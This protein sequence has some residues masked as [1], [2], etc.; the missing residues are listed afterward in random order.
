MPDTY[1][2]AFYNLFSIDTVQFCSLTFQTNVQHTFWH[3]WEVVKPLGDQ[4]MDRQSKKMPMAAT[5]LGWPPIIL[6]KRQHFLI[7]VKKY[8]SVKSGLC[9][10]KNK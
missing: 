1:W 10:I 4:A 6:I 8:K 9:G 3:P 2:N 7:F 5:G